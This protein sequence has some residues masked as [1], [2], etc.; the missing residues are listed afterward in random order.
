M[1][2]T[3]PDENHTS[4][5]SKSIIS[6]NVLYQH[7]KGL[8]CTPWQRAVISRA[9]EHHSSAAWVEVPAPW[10][11]RHDE[12]RRQWQGHGVQHHASNHQGE[13]THRDLRAMKGKLL[14]PPERITRG[15]DKR[16]HKSLIWT[17][18]PIQL[19]T[20]AG[21]I[22]TSQDLEKHLLLFT[23]QQARQ[24]CSLPSA[25]LKPLVWWHL[26]DVRARVSTQR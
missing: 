10:R 22:K 4:L 1:S 6:I 19:T 23:L 25:D 16:P 2:K 15:N 12:R 26:W 11:G 14:L 20:A 8:C 24:R 3:W 13:I 7:R 18:L 5:W 9:R 21:C 17:L